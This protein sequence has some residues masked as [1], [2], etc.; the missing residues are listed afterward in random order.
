MAFFR[1]RGSEK[2]QAAWFQRAAGGDVL[3]L[4]GHGLWP[5]RK[6]ARLISQFNPDII[7][8][9]IEG[10]LGWAARRLCLRRGLA[11]STSFHTNLPAY[12]ARRA[13]RA[14]LVCTV[15][16]VRGTRKQ[17]FRLL[18]QLYLMAHTTFRTNRMKIKRRRHLNRFVAFRPG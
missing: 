18:V 5:G 4:Q 11:F 15:P 10:P 17:L 3:D 8:I 9:A 2:A 13:P 14:P 6:L 1:D 7:H 12:I 16:V